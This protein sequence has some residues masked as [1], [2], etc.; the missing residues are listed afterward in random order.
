M[1]KNVLWHDPAE[2]PEIEAVIYQALHGYKD[3]SREFLIQAKEIES[4]AK[5]PWDDDEMFVKAN[6]EAQTK[7]K[8]ILGKLDDLLEECRERGK[9]TEEILGIKSQIED[10]QKE[11]LNKILSRGEALS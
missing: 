11:I 6:I 2:R 7:L 8:V 4:Y 1:L 5:R 10:I 3:R 9:S